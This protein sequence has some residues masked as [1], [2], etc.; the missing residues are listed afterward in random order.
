[1]LYRERQCSATAK[2]TQYSRRQLLAFVLRCAWFTA[3]SRTP[4]W[5]ASGWECQCRDANV[6]YF[7]YLFQTC[8]GG[9]LVEQ[10][11]SLCDQSSHIL[12]FRDH[13][14]RACGASLFLN[15]WITVGSEDNHGHRW[16]ESVQKTCFFQTVHDRH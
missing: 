7:T 11:P 14:G 4:P 13:G 15:E 5:L 3:A 6:R 10:F 12:T 8:S 9:H 2:S 1:D 16:Q